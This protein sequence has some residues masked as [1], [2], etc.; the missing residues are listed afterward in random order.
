VYCRDEQRRFELCGVV[1]W[2]DEVLAGTL[3][4]R[5][6]HQARERLGMKHPEEVGAPAAEGGGYMESDGLGPV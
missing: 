5:Y 3:Q 4:A 6:E 2:L 1:K